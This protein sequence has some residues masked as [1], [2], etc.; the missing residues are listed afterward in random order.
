M[1][2]ELALNM[3][4]IRMVAARWHQIWHEVYMHSA[5]VLSLEGLLESRTLVVKMIVA[6]CN[7]R[8][9]L[10]LLIAM[11]V[12]FMS[13]LSCVAPLFYNERLLRG[14]SK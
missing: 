2:S 5:A 7:Y 10:Y 12:N 1:C 3:A 9:L 6:K 13:I 11:C 14:H 4:E 8:K